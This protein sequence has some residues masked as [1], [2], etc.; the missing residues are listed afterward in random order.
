[1][2]RIKGS[3]F[4]ARLAPVSDVA[5]ARAFVADVHERFPDATHHAAAWRFGPDERH[6]DDDGEV[7]GTAGPP[8]LARLDGQSLEGVVMVVSRWYGG[9]KLGKGGLVRAYGG[10]ASAAVAEATIVE[11][12]VR[13]RVSVR[14]A[15]AL[16]GPLEG[17]AGR[18]E[19]ETVVDW[20]P[21]PTMHVDVPVE[22]AAALL[23]A[24]RERAAGRVEVVQAPQGY[25]NA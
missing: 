14:C 9:T 7:G 1:M 24:L 21:P 23:D 20:Q 2:P 4:V 10:A 6:A 11:E 16:V 8:L 19:G 3:R 13:T 25:N 15:H 12:R 5:A 18:F 22:H 17:V